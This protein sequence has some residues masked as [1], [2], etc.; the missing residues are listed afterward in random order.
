MKKRTFKKIKNFIL[1]TIF[2]LN[3][4]SLIICVSCMDSDYYIIFGLV[5]LA[6]A[7]YI[8]LFTFANSD[9]LERKLNKI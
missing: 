8:A 9:K 2:Y 3:L 4:S 6:N 7:I 1:W 5:A